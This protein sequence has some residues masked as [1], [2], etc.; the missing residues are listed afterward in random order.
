LSLTF[1]RKNALLA[2]KGSDMTW[3]E[4][5]TT[6]VIAVCVCIFFVALVRS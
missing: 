4:A 3:P 5:F 2:W 1:F 6:A